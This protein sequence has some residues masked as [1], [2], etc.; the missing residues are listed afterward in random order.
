MKT[1]IHPKTKIIDGILSAESKELIDDF[2]K[3]KR[4]LQ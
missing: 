4:G 3:K 2:F 1:K